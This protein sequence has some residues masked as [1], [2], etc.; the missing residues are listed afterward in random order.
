MFKGKKCDNGRKDE[1]CE[2]RSE[3]QEEIR[4]E[5]GQ[6]VRQIPFHLPVSLLHPCIAALSAGLEMV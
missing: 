1:S 2:R 4:R 5:S 6:C 3:T